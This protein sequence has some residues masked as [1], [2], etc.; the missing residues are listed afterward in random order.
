M[1]HTYTAHQHM[2]R[3]TTR[4]S[5]PEQ[6]I[7]TRI[8]E[9]RKRRAMTQ[10]ELA[11]EVGMNQSLLSRYERGRVRLHGALVADF[12]KALHVTADELLGLKPTNGT[13]ILADRRIVR[14]I[15][16]IG[17]LPRRKMEVLLSTIDS[18]LRGE[19][20]KNS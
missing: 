5:T 10:V 2:P 18:F 19:S 13:D 16:A 4:V 3:R 8:A 20:S 14:R 1:K 9:I 17:K 12:A 6:A 15:Q 11:S 7:G